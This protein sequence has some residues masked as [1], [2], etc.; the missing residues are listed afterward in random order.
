[1]GLRGGV[2]Y[3][4]GQFDDTRLLTHLVMTAAD[5]GATVLNYCGAVELQRD[6]EGYINGVTLEDR[7]S[8]ERIERQ[9]E[10]RRECDR[11]LYR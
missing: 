11:H 3:H 6:A 1:M 9:R 4:D 7:E 2:V 10:V 8:G 5:H